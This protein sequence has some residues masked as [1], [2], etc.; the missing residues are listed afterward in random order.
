MRISF[1]LDDTLICYQPGA[2]QEPRLPWYWR[3]F[4]GHEPLRQGAVE[5]MRA[6]QGRGWELWVYTTSYRDPWSVWCWLRCH[7]INVVR[8]INQA[9]HDDYLRRDRDTRP[10]S[11]NPA[12]FGIAL[13][14]DDS[15][16]VRMEGREYGFSVVVVAPD[17][18]E[19]AAKV[20][21]AAERLKPGRA[22]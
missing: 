9:I 7:G 21:A 5:L 4:A 3:L 12:A 16:G 6:L 22:M 8:V 19:W 2:L 13:H 1:D 15:E 20:L 18:A 17:D 14:V 11:K 10:P